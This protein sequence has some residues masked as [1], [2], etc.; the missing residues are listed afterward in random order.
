MSLTKCEM[1]EGR[2]DGEKGS[3]FST[4]SLE[5]DKRQSL[6]LSGEKTQADHVSHRGPAGRSCT[7]NQLNLKR[8]LGPECRRSVLCK[9]QG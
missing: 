8:S 4:S 1:E 6:K 5:G 9:G 7:G 3:P 2:N